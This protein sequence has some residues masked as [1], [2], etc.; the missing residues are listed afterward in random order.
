M[1]LLWKPVL[2]LISWIRS[3]RVRTENTLSNLSTDRITELKE[4]EAALGYSFR[5][6]ELVERAFTHRS[7]SNEIGT[8]ESPDY[9]SLEFLGDSILGFVI[10][11]FLY[12]T[13]PDLNEGD[14]S[15]IKSQLVSAR[16][17]HLL[18]LDLNLGRYLNLSRG[19]DRTGGRR[20]KALLA[21]L[22]ESLIAAIYLDGGME[23][24]KRFV[25]REFRERFEEI[26]KDKMPFKDHKSALQEMLH[27][28]G[29]PSPSYRVVNESGPDHKKEFLVSVASEGTVLAHG[30]GRSKKTAEQRAAEQ[31]IATLSE[32]PSR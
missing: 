19:E 22:F 32:K 18:S 20:K 29:C 7:Y 15:K 11:E 28:R 12:L 25:L 14:L 6:R 1:N 5:K 21:D 24:A 16:Q 2:Q 10:S 23:A 17:L 4:L 30:T 3:E 31:A 26:D 13:Y 27:G 9:E 8:N